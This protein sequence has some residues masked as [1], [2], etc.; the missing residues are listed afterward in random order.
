VP[1]EPSVQQGLGE[2]G[3]PPRVDRAHLDS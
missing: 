1:V 3:V 2:R